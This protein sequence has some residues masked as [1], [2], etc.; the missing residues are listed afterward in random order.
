MSLELWTMEIFAHI[1]F[2]L[3]ELLHTDESYEAT[4]KMVVSKIHV[5]LDIREG[6]LD[7][8]II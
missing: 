3:G 5:E 6:L 1:G 4:G 7:H 8:I 2:A